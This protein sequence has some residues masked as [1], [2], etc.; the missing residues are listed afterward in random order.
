MTERRWH[1]AAAPGGERGAHRRRLRR[2]AAGVG[3]QMPFTAGIAWRA[4]A[5]GLVGRLLWRWRGGGARRWR[6]LG[7]FDGVG[8]GVAPAVGVGGSRMLAFVLQRRLPPALSVG[9]R[10]CWLGSDARRR[11]WLWAGADVGFRVLHAADVRGAPL[12]ALVRERR[13]PLALPSGGCWRLL[14]LSAASRCFASA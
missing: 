6:Y 3:R 11:R 14:A 1:P 10:W 4:A 8:E 9:G 7:A 5:G 2:A 12:L 13:S